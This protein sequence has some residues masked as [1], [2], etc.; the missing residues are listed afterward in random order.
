VN[1]YYHWADLLQILKSTKKVCI[2]ICVLNGNGNRRP[3]CQECKSKPA[4]YN[5]RRGDKVYYRKK[6][7][8]CIRNS[9]KSTI[10]TPAWQRAGYSKKKS[11]E[12]C[13]FTAQHPYQLDVYYVD[14]N[15]NNNNTNNLQ[16]VC[17]NCNRLMHAKKSGWRQGDLSIDH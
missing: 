10:T 13:G 15:M 6:C 1:I 7:D 9:S 2:N 11:C 16:T 4:A 5:Y 17:A 14:A 8:A 12:M 3:L